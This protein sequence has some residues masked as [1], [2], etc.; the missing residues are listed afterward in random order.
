VAVSLYGQG[1]EYTGIRVVDDVF[2]FAIRIGRPSACRGASP[3]DLQ[4]VNFDS[5]SLDGGLVET[6]GPAT[7][8]AI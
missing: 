1:F 5:G 8:C 7:T 2:V 3:A 4:R 6:G